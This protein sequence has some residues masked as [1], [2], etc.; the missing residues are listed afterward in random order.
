MAVSAPRR[1][2]ADT[3]EPQAEV[4]AHAT[5]RA[6][7]TKTYL[8]REQ[9]W[10]VFQAYCEARGRVQFR[11]D[12]FNNACKLY[13]VW[14]AWHAQGATGVIT[15][16]QMARALGAQH[17]TSVRRWMDVWVSQGVIT[18]EEVHTMTGKTRGL[19]VELKAVS[20]VRALTRG[21][22]SAG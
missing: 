22:S 15:T 19:R 5:V 17:L 8:N 11:H 6:P 2:S 18:K 12:L 7:E 14:R 21:C 13:D 10:E 20:E 1:Q 9:L 3:L 16:P 4:V